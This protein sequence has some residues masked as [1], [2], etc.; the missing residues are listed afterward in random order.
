MISAKTEF[1]SFPQLGHIQ[2]QNLI[3]KSFTRISQCMQIISDIS[4]IKVTNFCNQKST[5]CLINFNKV[6]NLFQQSINKSVRTIHSM[7]I[8]PMPIYPMPIYPMP[9]YPMPIY[10]MPIYPMPIY[11]MPL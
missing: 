7:P 5:I 1:P 8:Y 2:K 9:I 3:R 4:D 10:P 11:P 6:Y